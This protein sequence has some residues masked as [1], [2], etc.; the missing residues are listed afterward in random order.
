MSVIGIQVITAI[1]LL[2]KCFQTN[3]IKQSSLKKSLKRNL[4]KWREIGTNP[5]ILKVIESGYEIAFVSNPT[6]TCIRNN[7]SAIHNHYV[8][9]VSSEKLDLLRNKRI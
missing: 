6:T 1:L 9:F 3:H 4:G 7:T 8:E 5:S 2:L